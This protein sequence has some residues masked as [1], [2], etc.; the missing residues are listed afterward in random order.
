MGGPLGSAESAHQANKGN[1]G[2]RTALT[3]PLLNMVWIR[4]SIE[5]ADSSRSGDRLW[6]IFMFKHSV[7][8]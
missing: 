2:H 1:K 6:G 8:H 5:N 3:T 7:T 4:K